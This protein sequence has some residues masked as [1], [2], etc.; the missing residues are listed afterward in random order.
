MQKKAL[1]G[2]EIKTWHYYD[3][4][5]ADDDGV[6]QWHDGEHHLKLKAQKASIKKEL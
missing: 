1:S 5:F 3:D 6:I 4:C 2:Q